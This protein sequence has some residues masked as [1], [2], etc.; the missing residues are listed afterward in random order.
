[1]NRKLFACFALLALCL[2]L[3][4]PAFARP[5]WCADQCTPSTPDHIVCTCPTAGAPVTTCGDWRATYCGL[6]LTPVLPTTV[7]DEIVALEEAEELVTEEEE[8]AEE[9]P[10]EAVAAD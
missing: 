6:L 3:T 8:I 10:T 4:G 9:E 5:P 1:M 7:L 2:T